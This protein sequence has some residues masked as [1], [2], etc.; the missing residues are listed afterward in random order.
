[1]DKAAVEGFA[2]ER[3]LMVEEQII[4]RGIRDDRVLS[5]FRAVPRHLFVPQ[6]HRDEAYEDHPI[7]IGSGQTISQPYIVAYMSEQLCVSPEATVLEIGTGSGY[8]A[9]V[10]GAL[11]AK[12][13]TI[14]AVEVLYRRAKRLLD[15]LGYGNIACYYGDG[16][17]GAGEIH[18]FDRIMI[19]AA[20]PRIP[21]PLV[22]LLKDGG[23]MILPVGAAYG[24]Q[25]LV[26]VERRGKEIVTR[27]LL[28]V[29]FVPMT[30]KIRRIEK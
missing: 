25:E 24:Y 7:S 20:A 11:A 16:Y 13:V 14:E 8:Q 23:S 19:T 26:S 30:G 10:L 27:S 5:A 2:H 22:S 4:A 1:M 9:A 15:S 18:A 17:T 12:V 6:R 29:R 28:G 3:R 21:K